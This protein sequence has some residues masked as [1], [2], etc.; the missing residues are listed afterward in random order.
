M[1]TNSRRAHQ[2]QSSLSW[3]WIIAVW[4]VAWLLLL[5]WLFWSSW[6]PANASWYLLVTPSWNP[7]TV[8][9]TMSNNSKI[10]ID[11]PEKLFASDKS[12]SV[13][14]GG[15][16]RAENDQMSI[17]I[18]GN[19]EVRYTSTSPTEN[20]ISITKWRAWVSSKTSPIVTQL[21]NFSVRIQAGDIVFVEQNNAYSIAYSIKWLSLISTSRGT[22]TLEPGNRI[23]IGASDLVSTDPLASLA[24]P[25]DENIMQNPIFIRNNGLDFLN[26]LNKIPQ[27][28]MT[29]SWSGNQPWEWTG[30]LNSNKWQYVVINDPLDGSI[31]RGTTI[32]VMGKILSREVKRIT[33]NDKDA[34]ISPVNESF[35][36]QWLPVEKDITNI[37]YKAYDANNSLLE[38]WVTVVFG[39]KWA[40]NSGVTLVP[41]NFP[42]SNKDFKITFPTENPYKTTDSLVKVQWSVPK[43][44]V[45]Y[46]VVND[47]RLQKFIPNSTV[48][49]YYANTDTKSMVDGINLYTIKFYGSDDS[50]LYSQ[51][52]T[53]VKESKNASI[54]GE[55][56]R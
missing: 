50:L 25:I 54:S 53:I 28:S 49:Y 45:A 44:T 34:S 14:S 48:W 6:W 26:Q 55:I 2:S 13:E 38:K 7:D 20:A 5:K 30:S 24:G 11:G 35:I 31:A 43:D 29:S 12:V 27:N 15:M 18:D 19:T 22:H 4:I 16:A 32:S 51:L 41:N 17:D 3:T 52:F 10:R 9:I 56:I 46:I 42:L 47:Y 40:K 37:V 8:A 1:Y 39:Q 36:F 23:M 33:L 21:K